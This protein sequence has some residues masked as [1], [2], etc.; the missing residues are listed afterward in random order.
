MVELP[1]VPAEVFEA[2]DVP[3]EVGA[4][5]EAAGRAE[6]VLEVRINLS[7]ESFIISFM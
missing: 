5:L 3:A 2:G 1:A 6:G 4:L 7:E